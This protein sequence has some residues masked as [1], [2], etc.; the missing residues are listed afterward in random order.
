METAKPCGGVE[1]AQIVQRGL[2]MAERAHPD[3]PGFRSNWRVRRIFRFLPWLSLKRNPYRSALYWRY[4]WASRYCRGKRVL[5][6]PCG[7]GWGTSRILSAASLTGVDISEE[8]V[9]D[10]TK[11]YGKHIRF[12]QGDMGRLDFPD[13]AF[14]VIC[15]LEGIE[16]VPVEVG[17]QFLRESRRVLTPG[18]TLLL[19]SPYCRTQPHSG[20]PY[21]IHE[22]A[23][24]EI[25]REV[26]AYYNV[27]EVIERNVDVMTI[28]YIRATARS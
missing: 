28:L 27:D 24:E 19:S 6:I 11:R 26:E 7:M 16:H 8:A 17:R 9:A 4:A 20:N 2:S 25:R 15:C 23:P 18:G 10:A 22:Y 1:E 21:H 13:A 14:D 5:D 3:D 12:Q